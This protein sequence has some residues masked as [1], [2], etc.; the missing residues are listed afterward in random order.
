MGM[1][2]LVVGKD[3][4]ALAALV[5]TAA[6][7]AISFGLMIGSIYTS[8]QQASS[9]GS[10]IIII[11]A[12]IGGLFMPTYLMPKSARFISDYSPLSWAHESFQD[13]FIR[14]GNLAMIWPNIWRILIFGA[15][16]FLIAVIYN[17]FRKVR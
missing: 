15:A 10:I 14:D 7:A 4:L 11:L 2:M 9:F 12:A 16:C 13:L 8:Q 5:L 17:R 3:L 6:F 1:P